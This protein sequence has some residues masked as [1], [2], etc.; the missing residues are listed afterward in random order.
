VLASPFNPE[1]GFNVG[2]AMARNC[3]I[4]CLADAAVVVTTGRDKGGTWN[5]AIE[6]LRSHWVPLWVRSH[7]DPGSGSADLVRR[8]AK[9]LPNDR[10]N[11]SLLL[12]DEDSRFDEAVSS[13]ELPFDRSEPKV[14][15]APREGAWEESAT[16]GRDRIAR[17]GAELVHSEPKAATPASFNELT[18]YELFLHRMAGLTAKSPLR[19]DEL[20]QHLDVSKA[21]LNAWLKQAVADRRLRRLTRPVRYRAQSVEPK[22]TSMFD[23]S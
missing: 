4:Y 2:N 15:E 17:P 16:G 9:W 20:L 3:Y 13:R 18:F 23:R 12:G 10:S 21:Q 19:A 5:G 14:S 8:G 7:P 11:L 6:N 1:A 22:Q